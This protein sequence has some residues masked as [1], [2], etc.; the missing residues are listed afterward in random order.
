MVNCSL[1][2]EKINDFDTL[3]KHANIAMYHSKKL[4]NN[5]FRFFDDDIVVIMQWFLLVKASN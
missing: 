5:H 3:F 2:S 1:I 4:G